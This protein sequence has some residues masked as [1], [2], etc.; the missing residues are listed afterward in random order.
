MNIVLLGP[1]GSGKG[2]Q[3]ALLQEDYGFS[4]ICTG[5]LIREE[6][7]QC[8]PLGSLIQT[9]VERGELPS[10]EIVM[11]L[12]EKK[13]NLEAKG[14]IFDG[15]PRTLPQAQVLEGLLAALNEKVDAVI[16]FKVDEKKLEERVTSRYMCAQCGKIYSR[17]ITPQQQ[18]ICDQCGSKEFL[19][20]KDDTST[21]LKIRL[22]LF[23]E[24]T[25][26]IIDFYKDK[27]I[28]YDVDGMEDVENVAH[29]IREI[30]RSLEEKKEIVKR[31]G[32][33]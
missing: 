23:H 20:R 31:K 29:Q 30:L 5:D 18:G 33:I 26:P 28:C 7:S 21:T 10:D 32:T 25:E 9:V 11:S 3:G 4:K 14:Y 22:R 27:K 2:T 6:I 8:S 17:L 13:L 19:S 1:P 16:L 12:V 24:K 15:V